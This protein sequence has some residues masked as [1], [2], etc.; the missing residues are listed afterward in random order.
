MTEVV[1]NAEQ[2]RFEIVVD[3]DVAG[4]SAYQLFG[5]SILFTHTQIDPSRAEH[6]LG[7]QLVK[8]E[9]DQIRSTTDLRVVAQCPFVAHFIREH[10]DYQDLLSR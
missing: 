4:F 2:S 10:P 5:N 7:S 8:A 3:G 9:L 6:G 1:Q